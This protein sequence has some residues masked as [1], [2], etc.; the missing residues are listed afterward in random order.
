MHN[1]VDGEIGKELLDK[2]GAGGLIRLGDMD[3][4]LRSFFHRGRGRAP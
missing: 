1:V 2:L 4:G 3:A